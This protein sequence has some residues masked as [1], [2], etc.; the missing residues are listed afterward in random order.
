MFQ[1]GKRLLFVAEN[2]HMAVGR[3]PKVVVKT[4]FKAQALNEVQIGLAVLDAI[5]PWRLRRESTEQVGIAKNAVLF[6]HLR[7]DVLHSHILKNA[8]IGAITQVG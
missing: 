3:M 1:P 2:Q 6:K 7:D 4:L 8:V 5:F